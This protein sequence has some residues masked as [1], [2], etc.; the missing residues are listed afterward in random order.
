MNRVGWL[1]VTYTT[2][3]LII[4]HFIHFL[5]KRL[6]ILDKRLGV[7]RGIKKKMKK[8]RL[9]KLIKKTILEYFQPMLPPGYP[10][11]PLKKCQSIRSSLLSGPREH[12]Y[13]CLVVIYR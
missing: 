12:I 13:G 9:K 1:K 5:S 10:W 8:I 3:Y 7:A 2:V 4:F 11:V 6:K